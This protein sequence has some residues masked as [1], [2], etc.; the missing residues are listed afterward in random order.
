MGVNKVEYYGETLIDT[1]GTTVSEETLMEGETAINAAGEVITG[2]LR[3]V[4]Y[5]AQNPTA[6]EQAQARKNIDALG[7]GD[8]PEAINDALAQAKAS[9]QFDGKD[10]QDGQPGKDGQPGSNGKDGSDGRDGEDGV[11]ILSMEQVV[12]ASE[13]D[14]TNVWRM[15]LT[16]GKTADF[17]VQNG[18]RGKTGKTAYEYAKDGGYTGTEE[19]FEYILAHG[20]A[21]SHEHRWDQITDRPFGEF[22]ID[23]GSDTITSDDVVYGNYYRVSE[24]VPTVE[25]LQKGGKLS[26]YRTSNGAITGDLITANIPGGDYTIVETTNGILISY[27]GLPM[28]VIS[29]NGMP[30]FG[31]VT[32]NA[33]TESGVYFNQG[34]YTWCV[35][36]LTINDYTGFK[37]YRTKTID[38]KYLPEDIGAISEAFDVSYSDILTWDGNTEGRPNIYNAVFKVSNETPTVDEAQQGGYFKY[39]ENGQLKTF[40]FTAANTDMWNND[41]YVIYGDD[42]GSIAVVTKEGASYEDQTNLEKG[43]YFNKD[44][45]VYICEAKFNG[46]QFGKTTLKPECL[47]EHS[48]EGGGTGG[49]GVSSWNDLT[50]KPFYEETVMGDTLTWDGNTEG[51]YCVADM[52]YCVSEV[53]PTL[54]DLRKG[55]SLV[56]DSTKY[57]FTSANVMNLSDLGAGKDCAIIAVSDNINGYMA[58]VAFKAGAAAYLGGAS[59]TFEKAGVYLRKGSMGHTSPLIINDYTGFEMEK[60]T[61]IEPKYLPNNMIHILWTIDENG[62]ASPIADKTYDEIIDMLSKGIYPIVNLSEDGIR[63]CAPL[64]G[65]T[66]LGIMFSSTFDN[67]FG[68]NVTLTSDNIVNLERL[69]D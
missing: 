3:P 44:R 9:G 35:H 34:Q 33:I 62:F 65:V 32:I 25:D 11:G 39:E 23:A 40:N 36:S 7:T 19:E 61:P 49:G 5:T 31:A 41:I 57:T 29:Y 52:F 38:K 13:D 47:P 67:S 59:I 2:N 12:K 24:F 43:I 55:G 46:Y 68:M 8:L 42:F 60:V 69:Y 1:T 53:V 20:T 10:G 48:H 66:D 45:G 56:Y 30:I 22:P 54:G 6:A 26:Y 27:D 18:A 4:K 64:V 37:N 15:T 17:E 14:G 21:G 51:L 58:G 63:V 16:N 28:V 50:D